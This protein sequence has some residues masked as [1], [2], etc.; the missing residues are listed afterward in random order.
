MPTF[1]GM[2]DMAVSERLNPVGW[3]I[4]SNPRRVIM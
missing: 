3:F 2:G 1:S 4:E